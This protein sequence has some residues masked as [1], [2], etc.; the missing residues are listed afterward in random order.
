MTITISQAKRERLNFKGA[1]YHIT[2]RC[3]NKESL[4]KND[5]DFRKYRIILK[6]CKKK[7]GFLLHDYIIM[8]SHTHLIIRLQSI[9]DISRI[10]Q[11]INRQYARW[12]NEHYKRKGHFW[13][14]RFYGE[15]IKDDLQLLAVMRYIDLNPVRA[16]LC[17]KPTDWK[18]SGARFYINGTKD[19]L[20]DA[21][22]VYNNL[23][24]DM[25][26]RQ[27]AYSNIFPFDLTNLALSELYQTKTKNLCV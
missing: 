22:D 2:T 1:I 11:A 20:M 19:D 3:N 8:N 5:L 14:D 27:K 13:E 16:G 10:M 9:L 24:K 4:I 6:K 12:Y 15:L 25:E 7:F 18:Y 21:P 23:G 17:Q 26:S